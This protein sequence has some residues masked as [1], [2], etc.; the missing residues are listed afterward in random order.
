MVT[1]RNMRI[2][3]EKPW[4]MSIVASLLLLALIF[5]VFFCAVWFHLVRKANALVNEIGAETP[6]KSGRTIGEARQAWN[7]QALEYL[8]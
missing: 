6:R 1:N 7:V 5:V 2:P 4:V 8:N 3:F